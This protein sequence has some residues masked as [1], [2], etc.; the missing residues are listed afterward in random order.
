[1]PSA[2]IEYTMTIHRVNAEPLRFKLKR[3]MDELR[4][5]GAAIERGLAANYFGVILDGKLTI[6][7]AHQIAGIDVEPAPKALIA[8]VIDDAEPCAVD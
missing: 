8:H 4:N 2:I 3:S 1:M 6:T 5:V 7:P